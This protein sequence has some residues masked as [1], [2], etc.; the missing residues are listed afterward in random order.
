[1]D[2]KNRVWL[3][4]GL[5]VLL[6]FVAISDNKLPNNLAAEKGTLEKGLIKVTG[7]S[8]VLTAPDIAYISLGVEI[9]DASAESASERNSQIMS[10]IMEALKDF[11]LED[12]QITTSGYYIYSYQEATGTS[13]D[14]KYKNMYNVRNQVNVKVTD[15]ENLG[16]VIDIA[17]KAGANQIQGINFDTTNKAEMQLK[18]LQNAT[19]Q[20]EEK[21]KAIAEASGVTIKNIVSITEQS[22]SYAPVPEGVQFRAVSNMLADTP[23]NPGNVEVRAKVIIEYAF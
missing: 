2:I 6:L 7:D 20:A 14:V 10:D 16:A 3:I 22:D 23:I 9:K 15:L 1:M 21:A 5:T 17:I 12:N 8:V 4:L 11:G 18:A 13:P 19:G